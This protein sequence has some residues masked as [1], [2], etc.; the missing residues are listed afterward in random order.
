MTEANINIPKDTR[1]WQGIVL[2]HSFT[3]DNQLLN[4]TNAI[5]KYHKEVNGWIDNGYHFI[6]EHIDNK[7]IIVQA[8]PLNMRGAHTKE[9]E[10]NFYSI[11]ICL[12]GNYDKDIVS[13]ETYAVLLSLLEALC[14]RFDISTYNIKPHSF[15]A[16]YKSC[17]GHRFDLGRVISELRSRLIE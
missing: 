9:Q 3:A 1:Q 7:P 11:G 15:F 6:I 8:R 2:H 16:P 12:I 14:R 13:E 4:N 17:P 5:T 10:Q